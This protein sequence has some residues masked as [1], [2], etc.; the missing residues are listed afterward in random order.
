MSPRTLSG[1]STKFKESP[2]SHYPKQYIERKKSRVRNP[3]LELTMSV[4]DT[5]SIV[6]SGP[7]IPR[8]TRAT[9]AFGKPQPPESQGGEDDT[10]RAAILKELWKS[11][12]TPRELVEQRRQGVDEKYVK[13]PQRKRIQWTLTR[14]SDC[15]KRKFRQIP[16]LPFSPIPNAEVAELRTGSEVVVLRESRSD[17]LR[18]HHNRSNVQ[19]LPLL[20]FTPSLHLGVAKLYTVS[21]VVVHRKGRSDQLRHH[22]YNPLTRPTSGNRSDKGTPPVF[23]RALNEFQE[24]LPQTFS[25]LPHPNVARLR[26]ESGVGGEKHG[27][28]DQL[29]H[30]PDGPFTPPTSG[31]RA[32][33]WILPVV[34]G[35]GS[36]TIGSL[37]TSKT[38]N[39][40]LSILQEH[41][42]SAYHR[43]N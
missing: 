22:P 29:R 34:D 24:R 1:N 32:D 40:S 36:R 25:P 38:S 30:Y 15:D 9:R 4:Q 7:Y 41:P 17:R 23:D 2:R 6:P 14:L 13:G 31:N 43:H 37:E 10:H 18:H 11:P 35:N 42:S 27:R 8:I 39:S 33:E 19:Q 26:T 5:S 28:S 16:L 21:G 3:S 12:R 20:L